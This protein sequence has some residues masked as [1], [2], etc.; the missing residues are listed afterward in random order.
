MISKIG[1]RINQCCESEMIYSEFGYDFLEFRIRILPILFK[2]YTPPVA[3]GEQGLRRERHGELQHVPAK[4]CDN[5]SL[6]HLHSYICYKRDVSEKHG[7][8]V[9]NFRCVPQR[10]GSGGIPTSPPAEPVIWFL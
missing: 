10:G 7:C 4:H 9:T 2:R 1:G 6:L 3:G 8:P 5:L